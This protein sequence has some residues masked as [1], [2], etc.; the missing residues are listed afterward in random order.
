[1]DTTQAA[2]MNMKKLNGDVLTPITVFLRLEGEK[3]FLLESSLKHSEQG[4]YSFIGVNPIK[5]II[6][7]GGKT[8]VVLPTGEVASD[9]VRR[10]LDILKEAVPPMDLGLPFPYCGGAVGFIGYDAI[11]QYRDIGR[12]LPDEIGMPDVHFMVYQDTIVFDHLAQAVYILAVDLDGCRDDKQLENRVR[13]LEKQMLRTDADEALEECQIHFGPELEKDEFIRRISEAK[14]YVLSGELEQIVLSQRMKGEISTNPFHFYRKLRNSNPSPYMFYVDF[15]E[16]VV[17]G[18]SPE[19]FVKTSGKRVM[20]NPI[21][22]TRP[23]GRT[24]EEDAALAAGLL[25]DEKE[26]SEHRMLVDL[27]CDDFSRV[28]EPGTI[29]VVDYMKIERY[30]H[31]MHIVSEVEGTLREDCTGIDALI[32]CL[33]AGTVSGAPKVRA[34]Q[35]INDLEDVKRG[36]Y[37]GAIGYVN[38]NG[39]TDF[40]LAIRSL[41]VKNRQA[42]LQAGAGIVADS[43]PEREYMETINKAKG[44]L[45]TSKDHKNI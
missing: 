35:V 5:E 1:M 38:A 43:I 25:E 16:Y 44:L 36:V 29:S 21:A 2:R 32:E 31:V 18:A 23:R 17:L 40:A 26:L 4:R 11:R 33:P 20:T 37:A 45:N 39:D 3:K 42:Y 12:G 13:E 14:G 7:E 24:A 15:G 41:V 9:K 34:M 19:S 22:G 10:A 28:C 8:K 6:G 30:R 27:S